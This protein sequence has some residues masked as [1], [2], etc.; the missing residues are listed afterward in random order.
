MSEEPRER[1]GA[2]A[3]GTGIMREQDLEKQGFLSRAD[4]ASLAFEN[5]FSCSVVSDYF[6]IP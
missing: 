2:E 5:V 4:W 3:G 1:E 6:V